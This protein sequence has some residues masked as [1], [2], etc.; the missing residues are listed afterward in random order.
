[1]FGPVQK[2]KQLLPWLAVFQMGS[3]VAAPLVDKTIG[4][5]AD[6]RILD[7]YVLADDSDPNT[8]YLPYS[9]LAIAPTPTDPSMPDF[10]F[11]YLPDGLVIQVTLKASIDR[12]GAKPLVDQIKRDNPSARFRTLPIESG[13]F[14]PTIQ[15][16]DGLSMTPNGRTDVII[17]HNQ[18]GLTKSLIFFFSGLEAD[19]IVGSLMSGGV[20]AINYEYSY[21]GTI[22]PSKLKI[23]IDWDEAESML[24]T[25]AGNGTLSGYAIKQITN[26]LS[27]TSA[28][29]IEIV[30]NASAAAVSQIFVEKVL[31]DR[32]FQGVDSPV[33][34]TAAF[35]FNPRGCTRG[36]ASY[37]FV[38]SQTIPMTGT[39]GFQFWSLCEKYPKNFSYKNVKG[40]MVHGCPTGVYGSGGVIREPSTPAPISTEFPGP[41]LN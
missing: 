31:R 18:A 15:S 25:E 11:T 17:P 20:F 7:A 23:D 19:L 21:T 14:I 8:F 32:C 27:S 24:R 5:D 3:L 29:D 6:S 36:A 33:S 38:T 41:V 2:V 28:V 40:E 26:R 35:R 10:T 12:D 9:R 1:M 37:E 34:S 22:T 13:R 39:A 4:L 16:S 30:G